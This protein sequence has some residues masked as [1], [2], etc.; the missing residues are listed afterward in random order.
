MP[1]HYD[2][3]VVAREI[4]KLNASSRMEMSTTKGANNAWML[5]V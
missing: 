4:A 5:V 3:E 1:R 2:E